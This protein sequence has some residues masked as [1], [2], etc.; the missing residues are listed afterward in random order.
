MESLLLEKLGINFNFSIVWRMT[1]LAQKKQTEWQ[2]KLGHH[3]VI[4]VFKTATEQSNQSRFSRIILFDG[5]YSQLVMFFP[6]FSTFLAWG[7][8]FNL[9]QNIFCITKFY[10]K[11]LFWLF[12]CVAF[13]KLHLH[14]K[15]VSRTYVYLFRPYG[16]VPRYN[17]WNLF[18]RP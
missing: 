8:G 18:F 9:K 7:M 10:F 16:L 4:Q 6:H 12:F 17:G 11:M 2:K 1:S 5:F 15:Y 13:T 3:L 14:C